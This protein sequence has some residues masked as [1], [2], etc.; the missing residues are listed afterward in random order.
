MNRSEVHRRVN[1]RMMI[2]YFSSLITLQIMGVL[3]FLRYPS[4]LSGLIIG[5]LAGAL[6]PVLLAALLVKLVKIVYRDELSQ[7]S[8]AE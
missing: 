2:L 6:A 8:N 1:I 4:A 5:V 7:D 3:Y